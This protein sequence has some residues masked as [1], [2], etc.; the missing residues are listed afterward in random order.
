[1]DSNFMNLADR[2]NLRSQDAMRLEVIIRATR[3]YRS[4]D[5]LP[6]IEA[7]Q[8]FHKGRYELCLLSHLCECAGVPCS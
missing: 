8:Y 4:K 1:M 2:S 7:T 6:V 5:I 3:K